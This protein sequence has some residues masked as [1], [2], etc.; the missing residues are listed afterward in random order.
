[1]LT[2]EISTTPAVAANPSNSAKEATK[3]TSAAFQI[4][5]A[6]RFLTVVTFMTFIKIK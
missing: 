6:K 1:M 4:A 2:S 5:G 3:T